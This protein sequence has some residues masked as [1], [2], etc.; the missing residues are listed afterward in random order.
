MT[1]NRG[2]SNY[3]DLL[4][5]FLVEVALLESNQ[6]IHKLHCAALFTITAIVTIDICVNRDT[7]TLQYEDQ[8]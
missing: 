8:H 7:H 2:M 6:L 5:T 3:F 1:P 4:F